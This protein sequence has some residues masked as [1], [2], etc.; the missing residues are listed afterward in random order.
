MRI[1]LCFKIVKL[2]DRLSQDRRRDTKVRIN[3]LT[4]PPRLAVTLIAQVV[5]C[6]G[7][8]CVVGTRVRGAR[9]EDLSTSGPV[10]WELT[11]TGETGHTVH[12]STFVQT[13]TGCTF[14]DVHLAEVT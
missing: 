2:P 11:Q 3:L 9:C 8:G 4:L 10:V 1:Q 12:T 5:W 7:A 13:G 6:V 14:V